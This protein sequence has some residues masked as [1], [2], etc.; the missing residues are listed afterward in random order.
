MHFLAKKY[1][2]KQSLLQFQTPPKI[3]IISLAHYGLN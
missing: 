3:T 2:K 1:F